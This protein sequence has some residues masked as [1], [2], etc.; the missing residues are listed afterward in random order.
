MHCRLVKADCFVVALQLQIPFRSSL[1][2]WIA[3][4]TR[5]PVVLN[6]PVDGRSAESLLMV[7]IG[8]SLDQSLDGHSL[9]RSMLYFRSYQ[10]ENVL[11]FQDQFVKVDCFVAA[12][13][14][15][16]R[17]HPLS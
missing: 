13:Q 10:M 8:C 17:S 2:Q 12:V 9:V 3:E 4:K 11:I 6:R 16:I 7:Q 5:V 15:Q 14:F 1:Q